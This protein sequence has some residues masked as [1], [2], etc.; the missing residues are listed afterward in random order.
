MPITPAYLARGI[1]KYTVRA[2]E[3]YRFYLY[4]RAAERKAQTWTR[5]RLHAARWRKLKA[6]LAFAY[7]SIPF[8]RDRFKQVGLTPSA[9]RTP[10]D[11]QL[12]P[13]MTKAD[14]RQNFPDRLVVPGKKFKEWHLGQTSGSTADSMHFVR[15]DG[16]VLRSLYYN[17]FLREEGISNA[18]V[19][20]LS[21]P[22]C[23]AGTCSLVE[24]P[25]LHINKIQKIPLFKHL[26]NMI[27]LPSNQKNILAASDTYMNALVG[28]LKELP[29]CVMIV[30]PVY[31]A[32][33]AEFLRKY[34]IPPPTFRS[35]ISTYELLTE[36][37]R[38]RF[39]EVFGCETYTSYAGSELLD[40]ANECERHTLHVVPDN[41]WV[42]VLRNGLPAKPGEVGK[43]VLTDLGNY[44]MPFIRYDIGDLLEVGDDRCPCG[45][46]T[47]TFRACHGRVRD[48]IPLPSGSFVTPLQVDAVF[49]GVKGVAFYQLVQQSMDSYRVSVMPRGTGTDVDTEEILKRCRRMFGS[50]ARY[51]IKCVDAIKP[52]RSLK[53]RFVYSELPQ[54]EV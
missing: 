43:A 42:E 5:E 10:E 41:A 44:N 9:I 46:H 30:D 17:V 4:W 14:I 27:G 45:R 20:I 37:A 35:I 54:A 26:D 16:A 32:S 2:H 48:V 39:R 36:S 23:T 50:D 53:Y 33:F 18:P 8:H 24:D 52:E 34:S 47:D 19:V 25:K 3:R 40:V 38:D 13:L 49:R 21:T 51:A 1:A 6:M 22:H 11:L 28:Y 29:D 12:I 7:E 15:P 31:L